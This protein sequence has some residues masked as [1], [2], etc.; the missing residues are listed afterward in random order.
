MVDRDDLYRV[1]GTD[2]P[3]LMKLLGGS[4]MRYHTHGDTYL[5]QSVADHTWRVQV[6]LLHLW[7]DASRD[8]LMAALYHDVA[9]CFTGDIPAP[10]K[11]IPGIMEEIKKLE[12]ELET[13]LGVN[14]NLP[15][16][17]SLRLKVSDKLELIRWC[18]MHNHN[19]ESDQIMRVG[20]EYVSLYSANLPMDDVER[21][22][23]VLDQL[24]S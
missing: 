2:D 3:L 9:E 21:I 12:M 6:I 24:I 16:A 5:V 1:L 17:D 15:L 10:V 11:R 18:R 20:I 4:V 19:H 8:L 14:I 22:S 7:P 13:S 23:A